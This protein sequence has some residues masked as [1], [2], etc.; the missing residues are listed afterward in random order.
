MKLLNDLRAENESVSDIRLMRAG[1][2]RAVTIQ[3]FPSPM[4]E[5]S[6]QMRERVNTIK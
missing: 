4:G 6:L 2:D 5:G 1:Q 3:P